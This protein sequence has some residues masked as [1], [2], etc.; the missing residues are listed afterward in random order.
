MCP[1]SVSAATLTRLASCLR[2]D[3]FVLK[4][5]QTWRK[6]SSASRPGISHPRFLVFNR[7][8]EKMW[9]L[10]LIFSMFVLNRPLIVGKSGAFSFMHL[11]TGLEQK[12]RPVG[13]PSDEA[14]AAHI[15][16]QHARNRK[17]GG[18]AVKKKKR[19][20]SREK[21]PLLDNAA[22]AGWRKFASKSAKSHKPKKVL[23]AYAVE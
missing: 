15:S 3:D 18:G 16:S 8:R 13:E 9:G 14:I 23:D 10:P 7:E 19:K 5:V 17:G 20:P 1:I 21:K 11:P 6:V 2:N 12:E 22:T 4:P